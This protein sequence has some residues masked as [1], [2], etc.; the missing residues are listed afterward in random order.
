YFILALFGVFAYRAVFHNYLNDK[1]KKYLLHLFF[2]ITTLA[3]LSGIVAVY[4][5]FNFLKWREAC[6]PDRACGLYGMYMTYGYGIGLFM[7]LL[8]GVLIYRRN[9]SRIISTKYILIIWM[10][11]FLGLFFSF[12]RG[13]WIGFII[14]IPFFFFKKNRKLFYMCFI[15]MGIIV[16]L[17]F[18]STKIQ[19]TFLKPNRIQSVQERFFL[20]QAALKAFQESP[21]LGKGYLNFEGQSTRIKKDYNIPS[22]K[23]SGHAHNNYMEFLASTGLIGFLMLFLFHIF[24]FLEMFKRDDLLANITAPFVIAF[25]ISGLFQYTFGDGENLFLIMAVWSLSQMDQ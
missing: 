11:N 22:Q 5:G 21:F 17:S 2:I 10:I 20:W 16:P 7:V 1:K 13:A 14:S 4:T 12:C 24:W 25:F 9:F 18:F 19:E 15:I 6:H 23:F 3:T 8:T